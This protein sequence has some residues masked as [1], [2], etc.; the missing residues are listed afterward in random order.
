LFSFYH[1]HRSLETIQNGGNDCHFKVYKITRCPGLKHY[2]LQLQL[3]TKLSL[4]IVQHQ[5]SQ[6]FLYQFLQFHQYRCCPLYQILVLHLY[7]TRAV[8]SSSVRTPY[9]ISQCHRVALQCKCY[10]T[11]SGPMN[12]MLYTGAVLGDSRVRFP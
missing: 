10:A 12:Y 11:C 3:C 7:R 4:Q 5:S 9:F 6:L 2:V 8:I 1:T